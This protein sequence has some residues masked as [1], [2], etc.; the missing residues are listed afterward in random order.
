MIFSINKKLVLG[1]NEQPIWR[2]MFPIHI[3]LSFP[4]PMAGNF[5]ANKE[6]GEEGIAQEK[7]AAIT[8]Q[9]QKDQLLWCILFSFYFL[10]FISTKDIN[11]H[12]HWCQHINGMAQMKL[13]KFGSVD[14]DFVLGVGGYDLDRLLAS[15]YDCVFPSGIFWLF[16]F[17]SLLHGNNANTLMC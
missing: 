3:F 5:S 14:M 2:V 9:S 16:Y 11:F 1:F 17:N 12:V 10:T 6:T 13:A 4:P 7:L 8:D 15:L